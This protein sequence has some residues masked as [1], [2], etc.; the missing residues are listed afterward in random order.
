MNRG[1]AIITGAL[2]GLGT[3][4]TQKLCEAGCSPSG[5]HSSAI[6]AMRARAW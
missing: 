4:M 5:C 1:H 6:S 3:A 2:G